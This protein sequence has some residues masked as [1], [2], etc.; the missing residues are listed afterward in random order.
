MSLLNHVPKASGTP[1]Q[2]SQ[3]GLPLTDEQLVFMQELMQTQFQQLYAL[4]PEGAEL[5]AE[6][7]IDA[8]SAAAIIEAMADAESGMSGQE[9]L[10]YDLAM[11]ADIISALTP[12]YEAANARWELNG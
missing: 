3:A 10:E 9:V 2:P 7:G 5:R 11:L 12:A 4:T 8:E 1:K 6:A